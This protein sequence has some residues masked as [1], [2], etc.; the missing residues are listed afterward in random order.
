[1]V[2]TFT[3]LRDDTAVLLAGFIVEYLEVNRVATLLEADHN[4]LVGSDA[5]AIFLGLEG[6]NWYDIVVLVVV[7]CDVLVATAREDGETTHVI[8]VEFVDVLKTDV[9][10]VVRDRW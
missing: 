4:A 2:F 8:S 5:V 7:K 3:L 9:E 10:F 6:L 1:M